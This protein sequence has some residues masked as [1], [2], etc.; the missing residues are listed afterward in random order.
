MT[1]KDNRETPPEL[2]AQLEARWH[3]DLDAAACHENAQ[4]RVYYTQD[5]CWGKQ[6]SDGIDYP[7]RPHKLSDLDGL[8]GSWK[9]RRVWCN[10]PFSDLRPWVEK[11]WASEANLVVMLVPANRTEQAWWQELVEPDRGCCDDHGNLHHRHWDSFNAEFLPGRI[12]FI[13]DGVKMGSPMF[14]CCLLVWRR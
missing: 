1:D 14:G 6:T 4:C 3:F 10:P 2:F 7:C 8:T 12:R 9:D 5:G 13:K 11:A